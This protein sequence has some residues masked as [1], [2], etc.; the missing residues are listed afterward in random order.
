M[1]PKLFRVAWPLLLCAIPAAAQEIVPSHAFSADELTAL[2]TRNW[3][4]NGGNT[5]GSDRGDSIWM[6]SL[7]G[8]IVEVAQAP[9]TRPGPGGPPGISPDVALQA[10]FDNGSTIYDNACSA[11]HGETG[12]GGQGGGSLLTGNLSLSQVM[13]AVNDGRNTMPSFDVFTDQQLLDIST[14]VVERLRE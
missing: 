11:C 1:L 4:T 2:L 8:T 6:F 9:A 12:E 10:D 7:S 3:I 13:L 14:F 5:A